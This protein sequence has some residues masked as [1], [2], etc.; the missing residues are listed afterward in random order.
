MYHSATAEFNPARLTTNIAAF[1]IAKNAR[2]NKFKTWFG[3]REVKW[4]DLYFYVFFIIF[5]EK[6][7]KRSYEHPSMH[8]LVYIH[9]FVLVKSMFVACVDIFVAKNPVRNQNSYRSTV[10]QISFV[11]F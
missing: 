2:S 5:L 6:S 10:L 4:L 3:K 9:P 11:F 8:A 7:L 1:L